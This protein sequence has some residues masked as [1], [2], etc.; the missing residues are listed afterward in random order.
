MFGSWAYND[1]ND[2]FSSDGNASYSFFLGLTW[3]VLLPIFAGFSFLKFGGKLCAWIAG[4]M[5]SFKKG[6]RK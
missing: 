2:Y 4:F 3:P 5:S 6:N 1:D